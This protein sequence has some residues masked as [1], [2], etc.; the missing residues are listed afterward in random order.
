MYPGQSQDGALQTLR[1]L[2]S[3]PKIAHFFPDTGH[4]QELNRLGLGSFG[5]D[6]W[7]VQ[8]IGR[9]LTYADR[10]LDLRQTGSFDNHV[11]FFGNIYLA[12]AKE[13]S[14]GRDSTIIRLREQ[15]REIC[16]SDPRL[17]TYH[18]Y[19]LA[20]AALEPSERERLRLVPNQTFYWRFLYDELSHFMNGEDRLCPLAGVRESLSFFSATLTILAPTL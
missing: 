15:V 19:C 6:T 4:A 20:I 2:F 16:A 8:G 9:A 11:A 10:E 17:S 5:E 13:I 3:H 12:A 7:Y 1:N 14:Y 18:A